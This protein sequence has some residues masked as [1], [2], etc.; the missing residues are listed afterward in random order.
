MTWDLCGLIG[1][2]L[3]A[4]GFALWSIPLAL[5]FVGAILLL[6]SIFGARRARG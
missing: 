2:A 6:L 1:V 5:V 3:I 4:S